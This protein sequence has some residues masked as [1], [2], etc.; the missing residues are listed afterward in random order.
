MTD[1]LK[2]AIEEHRM[3]EMA[4]KHL[5]HVIQ[6]IKEE[7]EHIDFLASLLEKE[8]LDVVQLQKSTVKA[9]FHQILGNK[10][11]Q[12]EIERQERLDAA[13]NY[14]EAI[15]YLELLEFER[16]VLEEKINQK[17]EVQKRLDHELNL[18]E[19][20]LL[21]SDSILGQ[22]I[23]NIE[24]Q[25]VTQFALKG[26]IRRAIVVGE[27]IISKLLNMSAILAKTQYWGWYYVAQ[28]TPVG[29]LGNLDKSLNMAY[30]LKQDLLEYQDY[31][32]DI[33]GRKHY[34][35]MNTFRTIL[36]FNSRLRAN[37]ISDWLIQEK[38]NST[39]HHVIAFRDQIKRLNE[40]LKKESKNADAE[41]EHLNREKRKVMMQEG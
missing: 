19:K 34:K 23:L 17:K 27:E 25:I 5:S 7:E 8:K 30:E 37:L 26:E 41:M 33:F 12:L 1:A 9:I 4:E 35:F 15:K 28:N 2:N 39:F 13:L 11:K 40:A 32:K 10:E 38:I 3:L 21:K 6:Q 36:S 31:L 29:T 24:K 16:S 20:E 18:R 14:N 22:A